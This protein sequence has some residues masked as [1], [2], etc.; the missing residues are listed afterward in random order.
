MEVKNGTWNENQEILLL[1]S[2]V[3]NIHS[4]RWRVWFL[5]LD[6]DEEKTWICGIQI[7]SSSW[8]VIEQHVWDNLEKRDMWLTHDKAAHNEQ[9]KTG[10]WKMWYSEVSNI[11]QHIKIIWIKCQKSSRHGTCLCDVISTYIQLLSWWTFKKHIGVD[12]MCTK[13]SCADASVDHHRTTTTTATITKI[14]KIYC[15]TAAI[16]CM[17]FQM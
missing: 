12:P 14:T 11:I 1:R 7:R 8:N 16:S 4:Y 5:H 3:M 9:L 17:S 10:A 15:I 13:M 6:I 2:K